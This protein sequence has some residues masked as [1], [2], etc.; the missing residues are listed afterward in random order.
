MRKR[1][2]WIAG[3]GGGLLGAVAIAALIAP[4]F[5]NVQKFKPVI[6]SRIRE[7]VGRPVRIEGDLGITFFPP[8]A[9]QIADV[10]IGNGE[11]F[12]KGDFLYVKT[13][14][15]R[16]RP[17]PLLRGDVQVMSLSIDKP[18][19]AIERNQQGSTLRED[20]GKK[21]EAHD[22]GRIAGGVRIERVTVKDG[23]IVYVDASGMRREITGVQFKLANA[24]TGHPCDFELQASIA[25][26]REPLPLSLK[27]TIGLFGNAASAIP[28]EAILRGPDKL[29]LAAKGFIADVSSTPK[30]DMAV[31]LSPFAPQRVLEE[32]G[33]RGSLPP[34]ALESIAFDMRITG[35]GAGVS[36]AD[37]KLD[38]DGSHAEMSAKIKWAREAEATFTARVD[39]VDL[40]RYL[41]G[42]GD[43]RVK[44]VKASGREDAVSPG[45]KAEAAGH[46]PPQSMRLS[47]VMEIAKLKARDIRAE[48]VHLNIEGENGF[49]K[50]DPIDFRL[51]RGAV[52]ARATVDTRENEPKTEIVVSADGVGMGP[53][54]QALVKKAPMEGTAQVRATLDM[55]GSRREDILRTL[56][57]KG[58]IIVREGSIEGPNLW[59]LVKMVDSL[60]DLG[61][62][63]S[64][65][66]RTDFSELRFPFTVKGSDVSTRNATIVS[67][68]LTASASGS[69]NLTTQTL[70]FRIEPKVAA[71]L[72][73]LGI[74]R[75]A[76]VP[77]IT[78]PVRVRGTFSSPE[79]EPD[80]GGNLQNTVKSG[81]ADLLKKRG[82]ADLGGMTKEL[83]KISPF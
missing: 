22:A 62:K 15:M 77:D 67:R 69:A 61:P 6:E 38:V 78:V 70:N 63:V 50:L 46:L 20:T 73:S 36:F 74:S 51:Y 31:R 76:G 29:E 10:H 79:F 60:A 3:L 18:L 48:D 13:F 56:S 40:G 12:E 68:L 72:K 14:R 57:G 27:G 28:F 64:S 33:L 25:G 39:E 2:K 16:L 80:T 52:S 44:E 49:Y 21:P 66:T 59:G 11:G 4:V 43:S 26:S 81:L 30:F 24:S 83:L 82:G 23:T 35:D 53:L 65:L 54:L 19:L 55:E 58:E 5:I 7:A 47:G 34:R 42:K 1:F 17:I 75:I 9:L 45:G 37:G 32:L 8:A 71:P 41:P